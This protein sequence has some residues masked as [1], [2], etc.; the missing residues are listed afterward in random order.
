[1]DIRK[2]IAAAIGCCITNGI[3]CAS[4]MA[5]TPYDEHARIQDAQKLLKENEQYIQQAKRLHEKLQATIQVAETLKGKAT[6]LQL[7]AAGG[8]LAPHLAG[9]QLK[10]A[11][12]QFASDLEKFKLHAQDY[13]NHLQQFQVTLGECHANQEAYKAQ[14]G[15]FQI[16]ADR[17]HMPNIRPP[18]I[19]GALQ[20]SVDESMHLA[21]QIRS[22]QQRTVAAEV[23][24]Q[25]SERKLASEMSQTGVL[26]QRATN[27][28]KRQ[29]AEQ[30]LANEFSRLRTEYETLA[31]EHDAIGGTASGS[32]TS[33]TVHGHIK[34]K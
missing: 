26:A 31:V 7:N 6:T 11:Q 33:Q 12:A 19:C 20:V 28:N 32:L 27:E 18:H 25:Q 24:L 4:V 17:F 3:I 16:H 9:A 21:N 8:S 5:Q 23:Q 15:K 2:A 14:L 29:V 13:Q 1:M 34:G 10:A 22:D 30:N